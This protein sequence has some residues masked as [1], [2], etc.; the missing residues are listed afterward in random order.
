MV[1]GK[2]DMRK[3][4]P[5]YVVSLAKDLRQKQT[6]AEELLW[7]QLRN[8]K[9]NGYKFYRQ[10]PIGR[11]IADFYCAEL[12]LVIELDG[13]VHDGDKQKRYDA[14][15]QK[16]IESRKLIVLRFR[17]ELVLED[18]GEVLKTISEYTKLENNPYVEKISRTGPYLHENEEGNHW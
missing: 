8:N 2:C 14:L 3:R 7:E 10:C 15:R 4:T 18:M 16:E 13:G 17:N 1:G 5:K 12:R 9:L 6:Q 11:Y